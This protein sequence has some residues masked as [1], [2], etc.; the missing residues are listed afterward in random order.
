MPSPT[1]PEPLGPPPPT[2]QYSGLD[3]IKAL[4]QAHARDNGYAIVGDCS[5]P[6]KAAWVCS[7]SGKYNDKNKAQDVHPTKRRRNTGTTKTGCPFRVRA[8]FDDI[9]S[10]WTTQITSA[11]HNHNAVVSLF[12]L[13]HHRIG[14]IT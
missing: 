5:T 13:P 12:A 8:T 7:K 4:L 2:S 9:T 14:A 1:H 6:K 3:E 10:I 11:D